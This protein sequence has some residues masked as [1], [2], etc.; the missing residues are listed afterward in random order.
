MV[1]YMYVVSTFGMNKILLESNRGKM[2]LLL[3]V[4]L[5]H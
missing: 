2:L 5:Q 1:L 4:I 3:F